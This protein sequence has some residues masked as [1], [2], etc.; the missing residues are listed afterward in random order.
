MKYSC[1]FFCVYNSCSSQEYAKL[2]ITKPAVRE[3]MEL[4]EQPTDDLFPC[5]CLRKRVR[6]FTCAFPQISA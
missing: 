3:D 2:Q 1:V 6:T 4:V 5:T